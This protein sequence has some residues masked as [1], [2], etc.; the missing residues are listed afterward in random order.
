[1]TRINAT[2]VV[3]AIL[4]LTVLVLTYIGSNLI[5]H[6]FT[7]GMHKF[8][9][10]FGSSK[11]GKE[12]LLHYLH[13]I[14]KDVP[15]KIG[16][17][18][19]LTSDTSPQMY[20]HLA[21]R[22]FIALLSL[23]GFIGSFLLFTINSGQQQANVSKPKIF[24]VVGMTVITGT[25][26]R[27]VTAIIIYGNF[28][29]QSYE[30]VTDFIHKGVNVYVVTS[31][32]NYS[33]V[34]FTILHIL[35][36]IDM[37]TTGHLFPFF[38]KMFLCCI[39][40]FTLGV[41]LLIAQIR[42]L[43]LART[44]IF[45]YLCPVSF[46]ITGYHGQ[47]ENFAMLMVLFGIYLYLRFS[48]MPVL[49]IALLWLSATAGMIIKHNIFYELIICLHSSI[50]RYWVKMSLFAVSVAIFILSF[51][52]Y[53]KTGSEGIIENV[54]KYGSFSSVYGWST[55]FYI[56]QLRYLFILGMFLFP[57]LLK[58]KDLIAQ[59]LLGV[60]FFL[61]FT[62]G[63]A[64]QYLVLPVALG[65][66]RPTKFYLLYTLVASALVLGHDNNVFVPG[67]HLLKNNFVFFC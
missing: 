16:Y 37:A 33:P 12:I 24:A 56:P 2:I 52:R 35:R 17:A 28:D 51:A 62:T 48:T 31:R 21:S 19:E 22:L 7:E 41:L 59:C 18:A 60:L 47:F 8:I 50:K 25:L 63:F 66:L 65:V 1:M 58:G 49:R 54:F 57:L 44:A 36:R 38:V 39:D 11:V 3:L 34:W 10:N 6:R 27:L 23:V 4:M 9:D 61:T 55:F 32:Y 14:K 5:S 30:M 20:F 67:F 26:L 46:L 53:W 43:P 15:Y 13:R 40:L 64:T 45:F 29:M 42:K